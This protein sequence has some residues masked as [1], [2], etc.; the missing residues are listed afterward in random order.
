M[1]FMTAVFIL[2]LMSCHKTDPDPTGYSEGVQVACIYYNDSL[3]IQEDRIDQLPHSAEEIG[4]I[5]K[6]DNQ[7]Y[8]D[9]ELEAARMDVGL[10]VYRAGESE[11]TLFIL[12]KD[13]KYNRFRRLSAEEEAKWRD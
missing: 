7:N 6:I 9:E 1:L 11:A 8:P 13:G 2:V 3:Y 12:D 4:S 5:S 10:T